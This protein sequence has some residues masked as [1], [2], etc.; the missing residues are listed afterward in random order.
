MSLVCCGSGFRRAR[1]V[2][3]IECAYSF[4]NAVSLRSVF[5][6]LVLLYVMDGF[7][8]L[9]SS[10]CLLPSIGSPHVDE[11]ASR[12]KRLKFICS[13][14]L[15]TDRIGNYGARRERV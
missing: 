2:G 12:R 15:L 8:L 7:F 1:E 6:E 11:T 13:A 4:L 9:S 10:S 14:L 5:R 3:G